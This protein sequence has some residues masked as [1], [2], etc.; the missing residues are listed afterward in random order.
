LVDF[1]STGNYELYPGNIKTSFWLGKG[2]TDIINT[3]NYKVCVDFD[4]SLYLSTSYD[5]FTWV[6]TIG[7]L[8]TLDNPLFTFGNKGSSKLTRVGNSVYTQVNTRLA[9]NQIPANVSNFQLQINL[10]STINAISSLS[11]YF[12]IYIPSNNNLKITLSPQV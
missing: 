11:P 7:S 2:V 12:D 4:Y 3:G 9:F 8:N 6:N 5:S 1:I 10:N